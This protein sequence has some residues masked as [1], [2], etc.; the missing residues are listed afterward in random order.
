MER[1]L[2][3]LV[4]PPLLAAL[5]VAAPTLNP[6]IRQGSHV[7]FVSSFQPRMRVNTQRGNQP[8]I[9]SQIDSEQEGARGRTREQRAQRTTHATDSWAPGPSIVRDLGG[10]IEPTCFVWAPRVQHLS[11]TFIAHSLVHRHRLHWRIAVHQR[12]RAPQ[13]TQREQTA[14]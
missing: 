5:L 3:P 14:P 13:T 6:R 9:R 4:A 1:I 11:S 12:A 10:D 7:T 8:Y 2:K